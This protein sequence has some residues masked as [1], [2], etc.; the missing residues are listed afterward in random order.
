MVHSRKKKP[1]P[2]EYLGELPR[3]CMDELAAVE[4]V[5]G[6]RFGDSPLC[7]C[8]G[9]DDVYQ[10]VDRTTGE[11]SKRFLWRCRECS[12]HYTVRKGT[13]MEDS[14]IPLR[15]WCFAFWAACASKK[16]VSAMQIHRQTGVSYKS[17][18]F[19]MHRIR[20]A[21]QRPGGGG[22]LFDRVEADEAW[23]GGKTKGGKPG[24][25][26][27]RPVV[28]GAVQRGGDIRARVVPDVTA[29]TLS[30][31]L[32][33][34]IEPSATLY[35]DK[36]RSYGPVGKTFKAHYT[37]NH[38]AGEYAR[39]DVHTNTI[40]GFW[41]LLKRGLHGTFHAVSRKHLPRYVNE[42]AWRWNYRKTSDG[43]RT[44]ALIECSVGKRLTYVE[45]LGRENP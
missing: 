45:Y 39:G 20:W 13:I 36:W 19:L 9:S 22:K 5:E 25:G 8:C 15:H 27:T 12:K 6:I 17:A 7:P 33:E 44:A 32:S 43:L 23:V 41:A 4:F 14:R 3:A 37:V 10:Q 31:A 29:R 1:L 30:S 35:T 28:L 2:D 16:G 40:E 21:M 38:G 24:R 34:W 18:L 26:T 11:R 42:F